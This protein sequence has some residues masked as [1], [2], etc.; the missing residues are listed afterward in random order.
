MSGKGS[1]V[2]QGEEGVY[3]L[4][5][6]ELFPPLRHRGGSKLAIVP[7]TARG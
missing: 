4:L 1:G 2:R 3:S 5:L 6:L 7:Q